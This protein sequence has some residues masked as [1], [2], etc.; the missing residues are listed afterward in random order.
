MIEYPNSQ[1]AEA[2]KLVNAALSVAA[3]Q[4]LYHPDSLKCAADYL[5]RQVGDFRTKSSNDVL[6]AIA[7]HYRNGSGE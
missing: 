2:V 5:E 1:Q 4:E 3:L 7:K 6:L